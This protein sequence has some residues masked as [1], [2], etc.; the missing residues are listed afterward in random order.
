MTRLMREKWYRR[1]VPFTWA[2]YIVHWVAVLVIFATCSLSGCKT[3]ETF[4]T[5]ASQ[6][7]ESVD[8]RAGEKVDK[9]FDKAETEVS[10]QIEKGFD[11]AEELLD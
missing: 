3:L 8:Q 2:G 4:D 7:V 9:G 6:F 5:R 10:R 11:R 1:L